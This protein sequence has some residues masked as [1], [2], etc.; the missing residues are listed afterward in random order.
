M[1]IKAKSE[2]TFLVIGTGT[3][4]ELQED[5][6]IT[7]DVANQHE[8]AQLSVY[9]SAHG[10]IDN[11]TAA[12]AH[13]G[14]PDVMTNWYYQVADA[15]S[16]STSTKPQVNVPANDFSKYVVKYQFRITLAKGSVEAS[17]LKCTSCVITMD[18]DKDG[19]HETITPIKVLITTADG[20][21]EFDSTSSTASVASSSVLA[22]T[23]TDQEF[24]QVYVYLWYNGA[25]SAVYTNN[26]ANLES[27]HI[28]L[29]FG[30][31]E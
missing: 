20:Y 14:D 19:E 22:A 27:A 24:I 18:N 12:E 2:S 7:V 29:K 6:E 10:T 8:A 4:A 23:V 3:L 11:S 13:A 31:D 28:E 15:P 30:V 1:S 16:A 21:A 5:N 17:N 25:D 9:P 26:V